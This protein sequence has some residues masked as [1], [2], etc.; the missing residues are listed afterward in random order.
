MWS[1]DQPG[2]WSPRDPIHPARGVIEK[3][4]GIE[5]LTV[6]VGVEEFRSGAAVFLRLT[7]R[8][9]RPHEVQ[10]ATFTQPQ[11]RTSS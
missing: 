4:D 3:K 7:F 11:S 9:D 5:T 2:E 10:I 8:A 6:Y 1:V